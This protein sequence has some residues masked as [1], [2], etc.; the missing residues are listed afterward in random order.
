MTSLPNRL[1]ANEFLEHEF[2]W[3]LRRLVPYAVLIMDIDFFKK[4]NDTFGHAVGDE[5]LRQIGSLLAQMLRGSDFVG[6]IGGEDFSLR[7]RPAVTALP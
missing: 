3:L 2:N 4:I 5:V 7:W 1:A 6:R